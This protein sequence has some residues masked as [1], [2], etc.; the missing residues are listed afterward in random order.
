MPPRIGIIGCGSIGS[1][2]AAHLARV[3]EVHA[4]VRRPEHARALNEHS[5]RVT[6]TH[7]F[8][9]RIHATT[10]PAEFPD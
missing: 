10:N 4:F 9:A 5:L 8:E 1:L 2:Y 6:G 3:A 7:S